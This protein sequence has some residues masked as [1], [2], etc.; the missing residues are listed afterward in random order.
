MDVFEKC[1]RY[2]D[3]KQVMAAGLYPYFQP[4][5]S[6]QDPEVVVD[7]RRM[8]MVG[9]NNYLGLTSHPR[10]EEATMARKVLHIPGAW[11]GDQPIPPAQMTGPIVTSGGVSGMD[12]ET[13]A[14]V[15][16][17]EG[18]AKWAF[19]QGLKNVDQRQGST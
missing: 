4:I 17:V 14:V 12:P 5:R 3:A 10:I 7:G 15:E 13:N 16:D 19:E 8:I 6:A 2:T 18:Q 11:H 1:H 9:S